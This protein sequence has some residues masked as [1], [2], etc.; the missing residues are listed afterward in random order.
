M[1]VLSITSK[2]FHVL[3]ST[4]LLVNAELTTWQALKLVFGR[5]VKI[6]SVIGVRAYAAWSAVICA[7]QAKHDLQ[8]AVLLKESWCDIFVEPEKFDFLSCRS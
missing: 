4:L 2:G 5:F 6:Q 1:W 7:T 3:D 8:S